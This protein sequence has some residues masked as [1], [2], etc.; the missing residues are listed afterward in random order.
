VFY[1]GE[2]ED[3]SRARTEREGI[4]LPAGTLADL[5]RLAGQVGV[6]LELADG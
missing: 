4:D 5:E 3:R 1:P 2:V 6:P